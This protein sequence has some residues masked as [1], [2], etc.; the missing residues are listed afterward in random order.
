MMFESSTDGEGGTVIVEGHAAESIA[1]HETEVVRVQVLCSQPPV[2]GSS[3]ESDELSDYPANLDPRRDS[4][5][6]EPIEE[7]EDEAE[8][9]NQQQLER[10]RQEAVSFY[11]E[12][13]IDSDGNMHERSS[14]PDVLETPDFS[15]E[16][17]LQEETTPLHSPFAAPPKEGRHGPAMMICQQAVAVSPGRTR[18]EGSMHVSPCSSVSDDPENHIHVS[19]CSSSSG[20]SDQDILEAV[21][22]WERQRVAG[23]VSQP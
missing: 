15:P 20:I 17:E 21:L 9:A 13:E 18:V 12:W 3:A 6:E 8:A 7:D 10:E 19:T 22:A 1:G 23:P 14:E 2:P 5:L 16:H 4:V 11:N